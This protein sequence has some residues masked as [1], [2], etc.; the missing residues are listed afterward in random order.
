VTVLPGLE[1]VEFIAIVTSVADLKPIP[2]PVFS[3]GQVIRGKVE[4]TGFIDIVNIV[5]KMHRVPVTA[6]QSP[7]GVVEIPY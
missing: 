6:Q 7:D 5:G 3:A 2:F 1:G 4:R